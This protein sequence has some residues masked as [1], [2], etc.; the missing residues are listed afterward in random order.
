MGIASTV[1]GGAGLLFG[2]GSSIAAAVQA[3]R[4]EQAQRRKEGIIEQQNAEKNALLDKQYYQDI[5]DRTEVKNMFR[6]LDE[7]SRQ[8]EKRTTA[9]SAI[10]GSTG[11]L[12]LANKE[13]NRKT[14]ADAVADMASNASTLRDNYLKDKIN[15]KD[16]YFKQRLGIED[17][18][19]AI[20]TNKSNQYGKAADNAFEWGGELLGSGIDSIVKPKSSDVNIPKEDD[21]K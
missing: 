16:D 5:T 11:E 10:A 1:I 20:E 14:Y 2:I 13:V 7:N 18:I 19:S 4:A 17:T 9:K 12:Q 8:A 6:L 3:R 15:A 21:G